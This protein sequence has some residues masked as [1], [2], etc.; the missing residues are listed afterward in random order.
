MH[1]VL[2]DWEGRPATLNFVND[3]TDRRRAEE[4]RLRMEAELRQMQKTEAIGGLAGGVAHDFNNMLTVILGCINVAG[5]DLDPLDSLYQDLGE[6]ETL[7][8]SGYASEVVVLRDD[9]SEGVAF[10]HKPFTLELLSSK[11]RES[12]DRG[13]VHGGSRM[14]R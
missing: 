3:V 8:M 5:S 10:I 7:F 11:V 13:P 6:V 4:E 1:A 9:V 14:N 2:I 12:L